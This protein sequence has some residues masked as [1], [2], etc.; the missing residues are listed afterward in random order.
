MELLAGAFR[1]VRAVGTPTLYI[2][3][4]LF[5]ALNIISGVDRYPPSMKE[6][7][8]GFGYSCDLDAVVLVRSDL[9]G[10]VRPRAS[11][12]KGSWVKH[13]MQRD[14]GLPCWLTAAVGELIGV[15]P[16]DGL[17]LV[18]GAQGLLTEGVERSEDSIITVEMPSFKLELGES[19]ALSACA[20]S[21]RFLELRYRDLQQARQ[22][23]LMLYMTTCSSQ[24]HNVVPLLPRTMLQDVASC[25]RILD[26]WELYGLTW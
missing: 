22:R 17:K 18:S 10:L 16:D 6:R 5:T 26:L 23:A 11:R 2:E 25:R 21:F 1:N 15:A 12:S 13:T 9:K 14:G 20:G 19:A 8:L 24:H 7:C 4:R 3:E